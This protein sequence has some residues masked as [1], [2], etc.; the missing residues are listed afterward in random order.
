MGA[1]RWLL[2]P[3]L[4]LIFVWVLL[5]NPEPILDNFPVLLAGS[6]DKS[7]FYISL[8]PYPKTLGVS[9]D[10]AKLQYQ[11]S[12]LG[13]K[14]E[15][16][17]PLI[18]Q[19]GQLLGKEDI[20]LDEIYRIRQSIEEVESEKSYAQRVYGMFTF[21]N[22]MWLL[23][24]LG[25][26]I[27]VGPCI[28]LIL[29]PLQFLIWAVAQV[30]WAIIIYMH[31]LGVWEML[32]YIISAGLTVEGFRFNVESGFYI[33]LTGIALYVASYSFSYSLHAPN[34]QEKPNAFNTF[35]IS[36]VLLPIALHYNSS[37]L[38]WIIVMGYYSSIGFSF[39]CTGLCYFVGFDSE[40]SLQ[41]VCTNSFFL[42]V[43]FIGSKIYGVNI[44]YLKLFQTPV[45]TFSSVLLC[46]GLLIFSSYYYS[47]IRCRLGYTKR[48]VIMVLN[49]LACIAVGNIFGINGLTNTGYVFF[50]LYCMEKYVEFHMFN[51]L[52]LWVFVFAG[53]VVLY[54]CALYLHRNPKLII[55]LFVYE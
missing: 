16:I 2:Y 42:Q 9:W 55:S 6:Q 50:V 18:S 14:T 17:Q 28:Y 20:T 53:S 31:Y 13:N 3:S 19:I 49:L 34:C 52:N 1:I 40:E 38:C 51:E 54:Y 25:I 46:L 24:I 15:E 44:P 21:V 26:T 22:F 11:I 35:M 32:A 48:Q 23:A 45:V 8:P 4:F 30:I 37:L 29:S 43:I 39:I 36:S 27:S 33:S 41:R 12:V 5:L 47:S 10:V 7:A